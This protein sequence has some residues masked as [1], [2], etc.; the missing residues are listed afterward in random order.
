[1]HPLKFILPLALF[2]GQLCAQEPSD[3]LSRQLQEVVVTANQ[4]AT[5]L[6]G[7]TL[8]STIPGSNLADLGTAIDVL[9]QLPMIMVD[10]DAVTV[11]GKSNVE[12]YIDGRP[13]RD[14]FELRQVLS[15]NL[16]TVE[17]L[18]APGAAYESTTGAVI[19]ITT[20][21]SRIAGL[22]LTDQ[23]QVKRRRRWSAMEMLSFNYRLKSWEFFLSGT[24]NHDKNVNK[25]TTTNSLIYNDKPTIVGSSQH[26][27]STTNAG[28]LKAGFNFSRS[29][30]SF[31]AY[32]RYNPEK[33]EFSNTGAEWIGAQSRV[34]RL[35]DKSIHGHS[36]LVS[37]YYENTF[38]DKYLLHFDGDFRQSRQRN[39]A[40]TT[41]PTGEYEAVNST[42]RRTS[43]LWA[44]KLYVNFPLWEGDFTAGTQDS[45]T[46]SMLDFR[47]L[48]P[49]IDQY[50][51]STETDARQTSAALFAS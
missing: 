5:K 7:S 40:A 43:T 10:D 6:V 12:I 39:G 8:V 42:D 2:C 24:Y 44:G 31:G 11:I 28:V 36:H 30:Q 13:M 34:N 22:S 49:E 47:M 1:M 21:P 4:P 17:L 25:G 20:R 23:L 27:L 18:M 48:N 46:R 35:I 41:Y 19:K 16:Q 50:I 29:G 51:P 45:Y 15:S 3:E 33:G 37:A 26:N 32:Y 9:G 14:D 38:A